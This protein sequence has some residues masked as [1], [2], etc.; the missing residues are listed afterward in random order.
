MPL[1][2]LARKGPELGN[3]LFAVLEVAQ[4]VR[5]ARPVGVA[6]VV[7]TVDAVD[8]P[9]V[10]GHLHVRVEEQRAPH[11]VPAEHEAGADRERDGPSL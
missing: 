11:V 9:D 4:H 2:L 7:E 10:L 1:E 8:D 6:V 3:D 5:L